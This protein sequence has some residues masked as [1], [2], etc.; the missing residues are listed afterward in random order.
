MSLLPALPGGWCVQGARRVDESLGPRWPWLVCGAGPAA[1][2]GCAHH[3]VACAAAGRWAGQWVCAGCPMHWHHKALWPLLLGSLGL[4]GP[5]APGRMAHG[6]PFAWPC[7]RRWA[8]A[9]IHGLLLE[10]IPDF[11]VFCLLLHALSLLPM[12]WPRGT[13]T[14]SDG[15]QRKQRLGEWGEN[16]LIFIGQN[17]FKTAYQMCCLLAVGA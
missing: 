3:G 6:R 11:P 8:G 15:L 7:T 2:A 14:I 13:K 17:S 5:A 10:L 1:V 16:L 9:P 4:A 12:S